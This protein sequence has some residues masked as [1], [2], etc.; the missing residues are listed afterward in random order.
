MGS[1]SYGTI[2]RDRW[3]RGF[4]AAYWKALVM[5]SVEK[6]SLRGRRVPVAVGRGMVDVIFRFC[7]EDILEFDSSLSLI[8][9]FFYHSIQEF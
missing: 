7:Y 1:S 4:D 8:S 3:L 6:E 9:L 2:L 5:S